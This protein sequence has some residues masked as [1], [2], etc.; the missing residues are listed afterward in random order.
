MYRRRGTS[1]TIHLPSVQRRRVERY[2]SA[3][4]NDHLATHSDYDSDADSTYKPS[5][6][7]REEVAQTESDGAPSEDLVH[8]GEATALGLALTF[9]GG[10]G[11]LSAGVLG[12]EVTS[13]N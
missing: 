8:G 9:L 2:V 3:I 12:A 1:R 4:D 6:A 10:L 7:E 13:V 11:Q 5:A